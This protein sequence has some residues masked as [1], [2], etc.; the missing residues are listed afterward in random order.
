M[1]T[2]IP[3]VLGSGLSRRDNKASFS[4]PSTFTQFPQ[5]GLLSPAAI[6]SAAVL[7][8]YRFDLDAWYGSPP[9]EPMPQGPKYGLRVGLMSSAAV[10]WREG[11]P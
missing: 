8:L 10:L 3:R 9:G 6:H 7:R 11:K 4:S 2:R 5:T 1:K